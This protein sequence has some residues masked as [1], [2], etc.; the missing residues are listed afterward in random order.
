MHAAVVASLHRGRLQA[1]VAREHG[2][3][4]R[5]V[6]RIVASWE[7]RCEPQD[8]IDPIAE[9]RAALEML[10]QAEA[11]MAAIEEKPDNDA[12]HIG[13]TRLKAELNERRIHLMQVLGLLPR[14]LAAVPVEHDLQQ[15]L[16]EFGEILQRHQVPHEALRELAELARRSSGQRRPLS[17]SALA[18]AA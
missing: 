11:D 17:L 16:R 5:Q 4:V 14:T 12:A 2:I 9:L 18:G 10:R 15:M 7:G 8:W 3:S 6:Q 13:A 1:D